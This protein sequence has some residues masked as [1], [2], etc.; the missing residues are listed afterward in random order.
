[1]Y[2]YY[3]HLDYA[4]AD[5]ELRAARALLPNDAETVALLAYLKR[6]QG[7]FDESVELFLESATLDP[8]TRSRLGVALYDLYLARRFV[9]AERIADDW[10]ARFPELGQ[11]YRIKALIGFCRT[12]DTTGLHGAPGQGSLRYGG[13][14]LHWLGHMLDGRYAEALAVVEGVEGDEFGMEYT[15]IALADTRLHLGDATGAAAAV[16]AVVR[17]AEA[18]IAKSPDALGAWSGLAL[19]YA[20]SD[21]PEDVRRVVRAQ[22]A[23]VTPERN[24]LDYWEARRQAAEAFALIGDRDA[25]FE[26]LAA[27]QDGP[28]GYCGHFLR[29]W[30]AFTSLRGDLRLEQ[31][32]RQA[33]W[34]GRP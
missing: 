10:M 7:R 28:R 27:V 3:G 25:A 16:A 33:D 13:E 32:A 21:R 19:M 4:R 8:N 23:L 24:A 12:G 22:L 9:V 18:V 17:E 6:R 26:Q 29:R 34:P 31:L 14:F 11:P 20:F 5:R 15:P 2:Y 1:M 30:P